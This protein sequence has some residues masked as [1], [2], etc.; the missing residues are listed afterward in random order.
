V[1]EPGAASQPAASGTEVT[2]G[3]SQA[4]PGVAGHDVHTGI[5]PVALPARAV[6]AAAGASC[7]QVNDETEICSIA[8]G[9][10]N[11]FVCASPDAPPKP[12]PDCMAMGGHDHWCCK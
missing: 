6:A 5:A 4:E 2:T 1:T 3:W 12:R 10:S 11:L 9:R 8:G 7:K